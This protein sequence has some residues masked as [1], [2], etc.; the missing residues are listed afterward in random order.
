[1]E[2]AAGWVYMSE[3]AFVSREK[4][5]DFSGPICASGLA[6][7]QARGTRWFSWVMFHQVCLFFILFYF[8]FG[9]FVTLWWWRDV[10]WVLYYFCTFVYKPVKKSL[11]SRLC[12]WICFFDP[13]PQLG[14]NPD[15]HSLSFVIHL[16]SSFHCWD[17][18]ARCIVGRLALKKAPLPCVC[19]ESWF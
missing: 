18:R 8:F 1:M 5:A 12:V 19:W 17:K 11:N 14:P 15:P 2:P 7:F 3:P 9:M 13:P 16:A 6:S 10:R 4:R